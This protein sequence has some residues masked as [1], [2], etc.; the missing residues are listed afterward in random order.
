MLHAAE[1]HEFQVQ[2]IERLYRLILSLFA[3]G[4]QFRQW[5]A[6]GPDGEAL[7]REFPDR[8]GSTSSALLAGIYVLSRHGHIDAR[9][10][11]RLANDFSRRSDEISRVAA[12]WR[13]QTPWTGVPLQTTRRRTLAVALVLTASGISLFPDVKSPDPLHLDSLEQDNSETWAP[14]IRRPEQ[15]ETASRVQTA[16]QTS[17]EPLPPPRPGP[18]PR[19]VREPPQPSE[20]ELPPKM[21]SK[22][23]AFAFS[24]LPNPAL[25][26]RFT[27]VLR[28]HTDQIEVSPRPLPGQKSRGM[29]HRE[30]MRLDPQHLDRCR[31]ILLDITFTQLRTTITHR[32]I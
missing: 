13:M 20:C 1:D 12:A 26:E 24:A 10:F 21:T 6:L 27:V 14:P 31:D 2:P 5:V 17:S 7:T 15:K 23:S 9:F 16:P 25:T 30:L 3:S 11:V 4:E 28:G 22:L 18:E 32:S 8:P 19:K 29:L